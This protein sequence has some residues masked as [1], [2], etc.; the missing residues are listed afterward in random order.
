M[1][2]LHNARCHSISPSL[3]H[4][5]QSDQGSSKIVSDAK[6]PEFCEGYR[7][8]FAFI[9][10]REDPPQGVFLFLI[11][12]TVGHS[13]VLQMGQLAIVNDTVIG[14]CHQKCVV[15]QFACFGSRS[16]G[17]SP[18]SLTQRPSPMRACT[19][20]YRDMVSE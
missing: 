13:K 11:Q 18:W 3:G 19:F 1:P 20:R 12:C 17:R 2:N 7:R 15:Q 9:H 14:E 8:K 4:P 6:F 5:R 16:D 10:Q